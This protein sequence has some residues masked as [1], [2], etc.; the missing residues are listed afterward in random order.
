MAIALIKVLET[1]KKR[2]KSHD[3]NFAGQE[4]VESCGFGRLEWSGGQYRESASA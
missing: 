1:L 2:P 4:I 3:F